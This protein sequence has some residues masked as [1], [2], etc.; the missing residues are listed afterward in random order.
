[1]IVKQLP[2]DDAKIVINTILDI[3][4]NQYIRQILDSQVLYEIDKQRREVFLIPKTSLKILNTIIDSE[5][6]SQLIH[7]FIK[8]GFFIQKKF[9]I[10]IESLNLLAPLTNRKILLNLK[11]SERF[12]FG[13]DL[14]IHTGKSV[15]IIGKKNPGIP[16]IVFS[17]QNIP[18]GYAIIHLE[19]DNSW[20]QN[21]VDTGIYLRSEK[22]AFK[23]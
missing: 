13:K 1:M 17:Y 11:D 19:E 14:D 3:V 5:S 23:V 4:D 22:T 12:I 6:G 15:K 10:G 16:I 7:L 18:L 20:I 9:L 21:L 2:H 8:L